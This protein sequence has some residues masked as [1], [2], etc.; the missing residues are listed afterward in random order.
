MWPCAQP[1]GDDSLVILHANV[2]DGIS[3]APVMDA[4]AVVI[5]GR[6]Q[7]QPASVVAYDGAAVDFV[8]KFRPSFSEEAPLPWLSA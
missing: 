8:E 3:N 4:S 5:N 1:A 2:I 7:S 6:I